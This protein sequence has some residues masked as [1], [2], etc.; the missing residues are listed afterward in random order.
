M[1]HIVPLHA[2]PPGRKSC[3]GSLTA[4]QHVMPLC[5]QRDFDNIWV[6]SFAAG[7]L[8]AALHFKGGVMEVS[9]DAQNMTQRLT[10][11][12]FAAAAGADVM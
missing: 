5:E 9:D 1:L 8:S 2:L 12:S 3:S 4:E 7:E 10:E 11:V 6:Q